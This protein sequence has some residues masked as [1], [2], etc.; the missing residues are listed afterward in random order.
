MKD[1]K[2][3]LKL[4]ASFIN[5]ELRQDNLAEKD[6]SMIITGTLPVL[7]RNCYELDIM[8]DVKLIMKTII[9]NAKNK[10]YY[11]CNRNS[12]LK[13]RQKYYENHK[14]EIREKRKARYLMSKIKKQERVTKWKDN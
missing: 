11:D 2:K 3:D 13:I 9:K 4:I 7:L 10:E 6:F 8:S 5:K 14:F 1:H 12:V